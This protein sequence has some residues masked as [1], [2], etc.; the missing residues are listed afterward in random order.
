MSSTSADRNERGA[1]G[2]LIRRRR[3]CNLSRI[4]ARLIRRNQ[5]PTFQC[6]F[7]VNPDTTFTTSTATLPGCRRLGWQWEPTI[8]AYWIHE[9]SKGRE[10][11]THRGLTEV[12]TRL[13]IGSRIGIA[14][15]LLQRDM[16]FAIEIVQ[17][18]IESLHTLCAA[19]FHRLFDFP[20]VALKD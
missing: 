11:G 6:L 1:E 18:H 9:C 8:F 12:D 2:L 15:R 17:R 14:E 7:V 10:Q 3:C 5:L 16:I 19:L 4:A 13:K 20:N